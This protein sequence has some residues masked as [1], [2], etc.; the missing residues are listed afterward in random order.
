MASR[1]PY[2][3]R[4]AALPALHRCTHTQLVRVA[5]LVD[6]VV[7]APGTTLPTDHGTVTIALEPT[8]VLVVDR[9]AMPALRELVP[10]LLDPAPVTRRR[11]R[12]LRWVPAC[13][14]SSA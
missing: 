10:D 8:R 4:L 6:E 13:S 7:V 12:R 2:L 9:R 11:D 5:Q 1:S 14:P 3:D